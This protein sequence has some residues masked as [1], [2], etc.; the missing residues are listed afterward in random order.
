MLYQLSY[1][2]GVR[3]PR[4]LS[5]GVQRVS[6]LRLRLIGDGLLEPY[7]LAP[8]PLHPCSDR[9]ARR[10]CL[11]TAHAE[12]CSTA[13]GSAWGSYPHACSTCTST[14]SGLRPRRARVHCLQC[15]GL[16]RFRARQG[17]TFALESS[18]LDG[19]AFEAE[20]VDRRRCASLEVPRA[21]GSQ[22]ASHLRA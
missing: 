18:P 11:A 20:D 21:F 4:P 13:F 16:G 19:S 7:G 17:K 3:A 15:S 10:V 5:D 8:C 22:N 9:Y 14:R 6:S 1:V 2:R 12:R